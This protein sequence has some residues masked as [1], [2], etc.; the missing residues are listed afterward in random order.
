MPYSADLRFS[1]CSSELNICWFYESLRDLGE[2]ITFDSNTIEDEFNEFLD[3][4]FNKWV[5]W[6]V[7]NHKQDDMINRF[8][9]VWEYLREKAIDFAKENPSVDFKFDDDDESTMKVI[10][11]DSHYEKAGEIIYLNETAYVVEKGEDGN[12]YWI[13]CPDYPSPEEK[14]IPVKGLYINGERVECSKYRIRPDVSC[15]HTYAL[16]ILP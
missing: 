2:D 10:E 11:F 7:F 5:V 8:E 15:V 1:Y 9:N 12:I 16:I 14:T 13:D 3:N 6:K 4:A